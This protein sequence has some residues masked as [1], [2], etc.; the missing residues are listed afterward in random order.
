VDAARGFVLKLLGL[1]K[2]KLPAEAGS[3]LNALL[4]G[5]LGQAEEAPQSAAPGAARPRRPAP[6]QIELRCVLTRPFHLTVA[7]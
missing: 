7:V 3:K 6:A 1:L 4:G 2:R 5:A